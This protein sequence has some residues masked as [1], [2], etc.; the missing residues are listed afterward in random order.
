MKRKTYAKRSCIPKRRENEISS[1]DRAEASGAS[2]RESWELFRACSF[3]RHDGECY[4][5]VNIIGR[6]LHGRDFD[7]DW[8]QEPRV[9][10]RR[11]PHAGSKEKQLSG[12]VELSMDTSLPSISAC[13]MSNSV[14]RFLRAKVCS[15]LI[16]IR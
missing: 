3:S 5:Q 13:K 1:Y 15:K 4:C 9:E 16:W 11:S 12:P 14:P 10:N 8:Q 2:S 7:F 6:F